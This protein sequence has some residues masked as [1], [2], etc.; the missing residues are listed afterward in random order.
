M[1]SKKQ[2]KDVSSPKKPSASPKRVKAQHGIVCS[3]PGER[4]GYFGWPTLAR[5]D[6]GTLVA[7]ASGLR[8]AHVCPYGR[9]VFLKSHDEGETWTS[10][11]VINDSPQDDRDAGILPLGG[12]RLLLCWF[13][14]DTRY[15]A[16]LLEAK[17]EESA[18]KRTS[19]SAHVWSEEYPQWKPGLRWQTD[20]TAKKF[21]G[22]W[23]RVSE[24][25]GDTWNQPVRVPVTAPH[26]PVL[27]RSGEIFYFGRVFGDEITI[28]PKDG[29]G[30]RATTSKDSVHWTDL[31]GVPFSPGTHDDNY[32]EPHAIELPSGKIL[33]IIRLQ[34]TQEHDVTK[35]GLPGLGMAQTESLD[36]GKT[37]SEA[38]PMGIDG[39]PPHLLR[40][41]S[42]AIILSYGRRIKPGCGERVAISHDEGVTWEKD[43]ILRDDSPERD[44]GYPSSVELSDGSIFTMYYQKANEGEKCS[45]LWTRWTLP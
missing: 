40:H 21:I 31:G 38:R 14:S 34:S 10:P 24:D 37:W 22:S 26:G 13:T 25:G 20:E 9:T 39:M 5:M 43:I 27:L 36:G 17:D 42:G 41:S 2:A 32:C 29:Y 6:D 23:G 15:Y 45:L 30:I 3:M 11:R 19:M 12:K 44:L 28:I 4:F 18:T 7:V 35:L 8:I 1:N 16:R 33:G